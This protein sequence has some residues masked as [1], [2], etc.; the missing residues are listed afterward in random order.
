MD[1]IIQLT[2]TKYHKTILFSI[3]NTLCNKFPDILE[4]SAQE[5][6]NVEVIVQALKRM[7]NKLFKDIFRF[8][9][10]T[11]K[12]DLFYLNLVIVFLTL[13]QIEC[14]R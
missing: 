2:I 14:H 1:I 12:E 6:N 13:L 8:Q 3:V 7:N 5:D 11:S 10:K 9:R 4:D